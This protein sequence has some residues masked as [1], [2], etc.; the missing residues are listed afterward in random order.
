MSAPN[1]SRHER[2]RAR[3]Q[4]GVTL[5]ELL[6]VVVIGLILTAGVT[7]IFIS[8]NQTYRFQE[9]LSRIQE[10]GRFA[11]DV[12]A[13]D[14]RV[15][16]YRGC[17]GNSL[18]PGDITDLTGPPGQAPPGTPASA[19]VDAVRGFTHDGSNWVPGLDAAIQAESPLPDGDI[20]RLRSLGFGGRADVKPPSEQSSGSNIKVEDVGGFEQDDVVVAT[21]CTSAVR[22]KITNNPSGGDTIT[23]AGNPD[24]YN[25]LG[26]PTELLTAGVDRYYFVRDNANGEPGLFRLN[27]GDVEELATGVERI[28]IEYG[29]DTDGDRRIDAYRTADAVTNWDDVLAVRVSLLVRGR[30][31]NVVEDPQTL[32]FPPGTTFTAGDNRLRQVFTKTISLR[33]RL[34]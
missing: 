22:F 6:V 2:R 17:A 31:D 25:N 19:V 7:Q 23:V 29:E 32:P 3:R 1:T 21:D 15:A 26:R 5:I 8:S 10:N 33:N 11:S 4:R 14:L 13:R 18:A 12:V 16:D 9:E 30:E 20:I 28:H 27:D 24:L 34:P